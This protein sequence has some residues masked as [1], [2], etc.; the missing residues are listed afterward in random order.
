MVFDLVG[1][2]GAVSFV[3]AGNEGWDIL[4]NESLNMFEEMFEEE[5]YMIPAACESE[6]SIVVAASNENDGLAS[7]SNYNKNIVDIAAPGTDILSGRYN[8]SCSF[9]APLFGW[10]TVSAL[11]Q[12]F[13]QKR[14]YSPFARDT[15]ATITEFPLMILDTQRFPAMMQK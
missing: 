5:I 11:T 2:M 6:Y 15:K 3:A 1:E 9:F 10:N 14:K 7:F 8:F 12:L 4:D 13:I